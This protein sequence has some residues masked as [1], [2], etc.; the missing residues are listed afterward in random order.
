MLCT[1]RGECRR[2]P[3]EEQGRGS[4]A[5]FQRGF[6]NA[7]VEKQL[8]GPSLPSRGKAHF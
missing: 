6:R 3:E 4:G 2:H 1:G 7:S 8:R 5:V